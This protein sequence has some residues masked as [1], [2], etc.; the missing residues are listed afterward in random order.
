MIE[1]GKSIMDFIF[2][3]NGYFIMM[4]IWFVLMTI[5]IKLWRKD[6]LLHDIFPIL[7]VCLINPILS[8]VVP[9][10]ILLIPMLLYVLYLND[11]Y[12]WNKTWD[13]KIF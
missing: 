10:S 11:W 4:P 1:L 3:W 7:F 13:K 9:I 2:S 12:V 5:Y 6:V 8:I